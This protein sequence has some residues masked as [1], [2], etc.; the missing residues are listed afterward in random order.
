[1]DQNTQP[2]AP[3]DVVALG[4][5]RVET[6]T[7]DR[8][9][10]RKGVTDRIAFISS[11]LIRTYT[12]YYEGNNQKRTFR[13]PT[14]PETLAFVKKQLG[15]P[16]Q[17]FG[18]LLFHY[19]TDDNGELLTPEKLS[20]K[21]KLWV[22]SEARYDEIVAL[23]RQ[24]PLMDTGFDGK[25]YDLQVKCTEEQYQRMNFTPCP[26]AHWKT[27]QT[28]Y[29]TIKAKEP[30]ALPRLRQALGRQMTDQ[31]IMGLLGGAGNGVAPASTDAAGEVDLSDVIDDA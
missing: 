3:E 10:G 17:K 27:K 7:F 6:S 31:E 25:Q 29:D 14:N 22:W 16:D 21:V 30:K 11:S 26:S 5:K 13:A 4:D 28:W 20:G 19:T 8:Y 18:L 12:F 2:A 9:K 1:M 24:W 15:E 23:N